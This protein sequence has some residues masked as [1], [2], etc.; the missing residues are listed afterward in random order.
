MLV[1]DGRVVVVVN[2]G[3]KY[4]GGTRVSGICLAQLTC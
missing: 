1:W 4:M 3:Q 2:V